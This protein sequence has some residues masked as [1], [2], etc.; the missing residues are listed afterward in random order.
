MNEHSVSARFKK[1]VLETLGQSSDPMP[2]RKIFQHVKVK[3]S[4]LSDDSVSERCGHDCGLKKGR[5]GGSS[6]P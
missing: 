4:V 1:A 5:K 3:I 2:V 6:L